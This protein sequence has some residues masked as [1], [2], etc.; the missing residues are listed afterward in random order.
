MDFEHL[1]TGRAAQERISI[2][3]D[4]VASAPYSAAGR[5]MPTLRLVC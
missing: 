1:V 3:L 5:G 4:S 2:L